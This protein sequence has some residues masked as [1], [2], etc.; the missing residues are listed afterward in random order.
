MAGMIAK[1]APAVLLSRSPDV[2]NGTLVFAGTRVPLKN[3]FDHL[4]GGNTLDEFLHDFPSVSRE[5][6]VAVL[7]LARESLTAN[8]GRRRIGD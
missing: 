7:E 2:M 5:H 8:R 6:A 4:E 1:S 3:L